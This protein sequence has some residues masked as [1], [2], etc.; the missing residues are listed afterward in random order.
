M[1]RHWKKVFHKTIFWDHGTSTWFNPI[2]QVPFGKFCQG[3]IH[4]FTNSPFVTFN[5]FRNLRPFKRHGIT[6]LMSINPNLDGLFRGSFC[7]V[8][9]VKI[10]PSPSKTR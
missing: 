6:L 3:Q 1:T 5:F 4:H 7:G 9:G 10:T 2:Y 8:G